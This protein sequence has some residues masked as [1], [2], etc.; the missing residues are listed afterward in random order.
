MRSRD[1]FSFDSYSFDKASKILL[2]HYSIGDL[3]FTERYRF[4]FEFAEYNQGLFERAVHLLF[5]VAGV[6]YF[7]TYVPPRVVSK[8]PIGKELAEF[9][10]QTYQKGLGEFFYVN[11]LDPK[12]PI[13]FPVDLFDDTPMQ[14]ATPTNDGLVIGL[15]GG[16]DSLVSVEL[17]KQSGKPISTWSL[18][19]RKQLE[20]LV[21]RIGLPHYWVEREWDDKI[22]QLVKHEGALNGHVPISAIIAAVGA[23]VCILSG[24]RDHVVSNE[25]SANEPTLQ[26]RGM[27]INHQYSKSQEFERLFQ[28]IL[29]HQVG[30]ATRY[31]SLLRPLSELRVAELFATHGFDKYHDVFS[32]CNRAFVKDSPGLFWD[33]SC[34]K[35]AFVYL[36]LAPFVDEA[37]LQDVIGHNLLLDESLAATYRQLLGISG[38]KPLECVGEIK[39]SRAAMRLAAKQ[40]PE[41]GQAYVFD[42]PSDYDFRK[43]HSHEMPKEIYE[44]IGGLIA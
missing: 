44:L 42:I 43:L 20:P 4:D 13:H 32:S 5:F 16:K 23:I 24:N 2:L 25:Q 31:Y 10:G 36:I 34:S 37:A 33:G 21:K 41:L 14:P 9:L 3:S 11:N 15:G 17:L 1:V 39:E 38:D 40:Y 30:D 26:Y 8:V 27:A 18:N 28:K 12:T 29:H 7:K 22:G 6:S 35:C 19:H